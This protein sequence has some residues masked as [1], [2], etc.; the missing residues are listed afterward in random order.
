[1]QGAAVGPDG[2]LYLMD[3]YPQLNVGCFPGLTAPKK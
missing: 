2:S 3:I 1:M